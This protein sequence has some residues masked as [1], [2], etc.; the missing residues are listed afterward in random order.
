MSLEAH[1]PD[2]EDPEKR[3]KTVGKCVWE[4]DV[5]CMFDR[6]DDNAILGPWKARNMNHVYKKIHYGKRME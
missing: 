5:D 3:Y 1:K 6:D 4:R 2:L